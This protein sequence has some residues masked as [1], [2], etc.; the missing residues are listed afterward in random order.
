MSML[1]MCN[2]QELLDIDWDSG[3]GDIT[4][5]HNYA[6]CAASHL[7][8]FVLGTRQVQTEFYR[9]CLPMLSRSLV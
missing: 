4:L 9:R 1:E 5:L 8:L 6:W 7:H 3:F 2:V